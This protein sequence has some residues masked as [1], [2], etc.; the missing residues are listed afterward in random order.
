MCHLWFRRWRRWRRRRRV[1]VIR[2]K[3]RL[4]QWRQ[5]GSWFILFTLNGRRY[6]GRDGTRKR[7]S[8][9]VMRVSDGIRDCFL[10]KIKIVYW[11]KRWSE[12]VCV[13]QLWRSIQMNRRVCSI[14]S[15]AATARRDG[16]RG[17]FVEQNEIDYF[18]NF[19]LQVLLILEVVL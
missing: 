12:R 14:A 18:L 7:R 9:R 13:G 16:R 10:I 4:W 2:R 15:T 19:H 1:W 5:W 3:R 6:G 8:I 17:G 11:F